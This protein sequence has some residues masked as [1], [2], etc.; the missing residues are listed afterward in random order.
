MSIKDELKSED[1]VKHCRVCSEEINWTNT[2]TEAGWAEV[3]I[4]CTCE[5]CFDNATFDMEE[6][7]EKLAHSIRKLV[8]ESP[9]VVLAGGALRMLVDPCNEEICDYDLFVT[10]QSVLEKLLADIQSLGYTKVFECPKRELFTF[11][12]ADEP[13]IQVINKRP[14]KDCRDIVSSFDITACCAAWDGENFY[15]HGRFIFDVLNKRIN[16]NVVGYPNA[17]LK[18]IVK[19]VL[20]GYTLT[21]QANDFFISSVNQMELTEENRVMYVD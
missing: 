9:S 5:R 7:I 8:H 17:T 6:N 19:Y 13:K 1:Q 21:P 10:D 3:G 16:L 15:K 11:V 4:T 12:T 14:Y 18:R 2:A 20:K